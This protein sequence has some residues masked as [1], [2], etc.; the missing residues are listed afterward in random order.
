MWRKY[1]LLVLLAIL[2]VGGAFFLS[3]SAATPNESDYVK[4]V[5]SYQAISIDEVEQ[6]VQDEEEFILYTRGASSFQTTIKSPNGL[7]CK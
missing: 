4:A 3:Q 5:K 7:Y 1:F 2:V 6:K